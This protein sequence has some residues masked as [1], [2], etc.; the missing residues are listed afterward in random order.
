M[1]RNETS[2]IAGLPVVRTEREIGALSLQIHMIRSYYEDQRRITGVKEFAKS[3]GAEIQMVNLVMLTMDAHPDWS[4]EQVLEQM[5]GERTGGE[6]SDREAEPPA[7][8]T[9]GA[10]A[11]PAKGRKGKKPPKSETPEEADSG[12]KKGVYSGKRI[13]I[14]ADPRI[15]V[16]KIGKAYYIYYT[17]ARE[18]HKDKQYSIPKS[19]V[20][21][22]RGP[23]EFPGEMYPN[24]KFY[25][26][27]P[28]A[29]R[30]LEENAG[31]SPLKK[32]QFKRDQVSRLMLVCQDLYKDLAEYVENHR[33]D[34]PDTFTMPEVPA[35]WKQT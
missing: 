30:L 20:I 1:S 19:T 15:T 33:S 18:Y 24:E 2:G 22:K 14:P 11:S 10:G 28:D 5:V 16:K 25:Q 35:S 23:P 21:G 4:D 13:P 27:F 29:E 17:Y 8:S 34:I 32:A 26:Y 7:P 6:Q 3:I 31:P 12:K 9:K